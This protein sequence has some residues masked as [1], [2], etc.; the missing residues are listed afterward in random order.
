MAKR[1]VPMC[2]LV[3]IL[4]ACEAG[5]DAVHV[6]TASMT[7]MALPEVLRTVAA[8]DPSGLQ[9]QVTVDDVPTTLVSDENNIWRGSVQ[10]PMNQT[11]RFPAS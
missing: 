2:V 4:T 3:A 6:S 9:L 7:E 1:S 11:S 10:V 8:I 5:T